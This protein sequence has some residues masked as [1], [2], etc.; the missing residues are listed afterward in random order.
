[1]PKK[2]EKMYPRV[3]T[4]KHELFTFVETAKQ[5]V[6]VCVGNHQVSGRTFKTIAEAKNYVNSYSWEL[7]CNIASLVAQQTYKQL[8]DKQHEETK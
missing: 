4:D 1:M 3:H 8:N 5:N 7:I 6:V 2:I